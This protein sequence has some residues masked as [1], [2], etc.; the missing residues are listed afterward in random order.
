MA[1]GPKYRVRMKLKRH[2]GI[3][4]D[5]MIMFFQQLATLVN[6]GTP[7][8]Q[9]LLLAGDQNESVK[10][11]KIGSELA[12]GVAA[13]Q[14]LYAV[15]EQ[16]PKVFKSHW[17]Q[18]IRVGELTGQLGSILTQLRFHLE[19]QKEM[20]GKIVS[21]LTYPVILLGVA[22]SSVTIMLWKVIPT[23]AGFF[24]DMG[25]ELPKITQYVLAFSDFVQSKGPYILL[26]LIILSF[27]IK[28]YIST[29]KGRKVFSQFI[30]MIPGVGELMVLI[31][32][33]KFAG[34][35]GLLL[36]SGTPLMEALTTVQEMFI[37]NF[38]YYETFGEVSKS[39]A[40]GGG[41]SDSLGDTYLFTPMVTNMVRIGE[42]SG[43]LP[44]VLA[45]LSDFYGSKV[46]GKLLSVTGALEPI[47]V[48]FMGVAVAG[49]LGSVYL[50]M[51][52]LSAGGGA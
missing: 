3:K 20:R 12:A 14:S 39:V 35:L 22:V 10:L 2:P 11:S 34:N 51:F 5:D 40:A 50:P 21:A 8:L 24:D 27:L 46:E 15:A 44:D 9:A 23:F 6:S 28:K 7:I 30:M 32:M 48:I 33:E 47:I 16:Y 45:E 17:V 38:I 1:R 37:S 52:Q 4:T 19:K 31:T 49:L 13:G 41:L 43:N 36:K 42:E 26:S 25:G 29:E 18:M